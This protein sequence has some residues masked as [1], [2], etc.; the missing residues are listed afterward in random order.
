MATLRFDIEKV[1]GIANFNLW[2][3]RMTA[4][5]VQKGLKNVVTGKKP[6]DTNQLEW[7]QLDEKALSI[8]QLCLTNNV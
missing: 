8:I 3:V 4:I 6:A 1:N 7:E 2:K 5:L